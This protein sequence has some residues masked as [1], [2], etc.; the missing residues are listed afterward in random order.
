MKCRCPHNWT[1]PWTSRLTGAH[2]TSDNLPQCGKSRSWSVWED[3]TPSVYSPTGRM[4]GPPWWGWA[5]TATGSFLPSPPP[6]TDMK[7]CIQ[8]VRAQRAWFNTEAL[9]KRRTGWGCKIVVGE[10]RRGVRVAAPVNALIILMKDWIAC[11]VCDDGAATY[12]VR[13]LEPH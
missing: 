10:G 7:P 5:D 12:L 1:A 11:F 13:F 4:S 9:R 8:T 3:L 6:P 2:V